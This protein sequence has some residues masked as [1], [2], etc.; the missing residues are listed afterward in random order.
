MRA[1]ETLDQ[2]TAP[3]RVAIVGAS[4]NP[5]RIGGRPI[6]YML[7]HGYTG[8]I[9]PVNP[10]NETIQG[11]PAYAQ[12][13]EIPE[14]IDFALI[15]VKS[16][17]VAE[18]VRAAAQKGARTALIFSSG[19]AEMDASGRALQEE[20]VEIGNNTGI[21]I[22]G[23]NCLGLF[24]A[25]S[26]FF[27]T[28]TATIDRAKPEVGGVGIASQSG[29]YG[30]HIYMACH[31]RG[32][33][34][35]HWVTTGNEADIEVAEVIKL[36]A[37]DESVHTILAYVESVKDGALMIDALE[38]A[39]ANRKPVIVTKVG[40]SEI[41]AAAAASHTA[42][43]AGE[44]KIYDAIFRQYG[45]FR[46]SST[47]EMTDL[48]VAAKPRIYP[49]GKKV[50]LVTIS[51]GA[52]ILMADAADA[53]GLDV[54]PM[55]KESQDELKEIV[56]FA[57]PVNPVDVTAQFF[58][59]LSLVPRFTRAMLDKGGYD[60]LVG[61]W[62][63]IAGSPILG[64]PLLAY[65]SETMASYEDRLF[66]HV[67]LAEEDM[68][69]KYQDNGFPTFSDPTR[70]LV[71]LNGMMFFGQ[72]F[73]NNTQEDTPDLPAPT[74]LE[75]N[76]NEQQTKAVLASFDLPVVEDR[77]CLS[78]EDVRDGFAAAGRP[79]AMK[80]L[81]PDILHKT[82]IGGV[83]LNLKTEDEAVFAYQQ[84]LDNALQ[85]APDAKI[86]G[87]MLSPMIGDGVDL[88]L[89]AQT[90]PIFGAMVMVGIGGIHA[91]LLKDVTF[92][93]APISAF[94]AHTMLERL[95]L[96]PLLTGVR[97]AESCDI[98]AVAKTISDF[99][100]FIAAHSDQLSSFEINP[101]RALPDGCVALDAL[102]VCKVSGG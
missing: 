73:A 92:M 89:G 78:V 80:I 25:Q 95:Q 53:L 20:L 37:T 8:Q 76:M 72:S 2:L 13:S 28:F 36:M 56:P 102:A 54:A 71:A 90:D 93:R 7:N 27:P 57:S 44:D 19:F 11:L 99:S 68:H 98:D 69:R 46:V 38:T 29:A 91:E 17:M 6:S 86:D 85:H 40:Q 12:I 4:D 65:L 18:Q 39:R 14:E 5:T 83:M 31:S 62:T 42:S 32:L 70:A 94:A 22:L 88:I 26:C 84:I 33:G 60:A 66:L 50:G 96:Y 75:A 63:S 43:L 74:R 34:I 58:N 35:N 82:D 77:L 48:A 41:G 47:E 30:S 15:A 61:F 64:E 23:P 10:K 100:A 9:F 3:Q 51:G 16:T 24:N 67:M 55:P 49:A 45:A 52:G 87:V 97:G 81:S 59:D 101:L 21:R 79:V 1:Y